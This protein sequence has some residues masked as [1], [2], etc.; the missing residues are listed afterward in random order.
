MDGGLT[1]Y[2]TLESNGYK[3]YMNRFALNVV[4]K[5]CNLLG[6]RGG[7]LKDHIGSQ[8]GGGRSRWVEKGS[9]NI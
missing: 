9:H 7:A 4:Q 3:S 8:G 1:P 5:L 2:L 6:G